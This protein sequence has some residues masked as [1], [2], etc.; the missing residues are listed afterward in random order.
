M[1]GV[2]LK[3]PIILLLP[4]HV[5]VD[6]RNGAFPVVIVLGKFS[7]SN[8]QD[9]NQNNIAQHDIETHD[10][11]VPKGNDIA[12]WKRNNDQ[13]NDPC[14]EGTSISPPRVLFIAMM[15]HHQ[16]IICQGCHKRGRWENVA[17]EIKEEGVAGENHCRN[18]TRHAR[19]T[20]ENR[21][22]DIV[23]KDIGKEHFA[24][25]KGHGNDPRSSKGEPRKVERNEQNLI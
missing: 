12:Q 15:L 16:D 11:I 10:I 5:N 13:Q 22:D 14:G 24:I 18:Y 17:I 21:K 2:K 8:D 9:G 19:E 20:I 1:Q 3:R 23:D 7:L 4:A 6:A 25:V